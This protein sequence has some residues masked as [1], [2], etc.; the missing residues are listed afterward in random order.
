MDTKGILTNLLCNTKFS[1]MVAEVA[2]KPLMQTITDGI[3]KYLIDIPTNAIADGLTKIGLDSVGNVIGTVGDKAV[4]GLSNIAAGNIVG[5]KDLY[6]GADTLVG[7]ILPGGQKFAEGYLGQLY[8]GADKMFGGYLP[9]VGGAGY[10]APNATNATLATTGGDTMVSDGFLRSQDVYGPQF[11]DARLLDGTPMK[12]SP[13][14]TPLFSMAPPMSGIDKFMSIAQPTVKLAGAVGTIASMLDGKGGGGG[15]R[16]PTAAKGGNTGTRSSSGLSRRSNLDAPEDK[17]GGS[18][19]GL[20]MGR[21][22]ISDQIEASASSDTDAVTSGETN[23]ELG[24]TQATR[25]LESSAGMSPDQ[26]ANMA[27]GD[28]DNLIAEALATESAVE[29]QEEVEGEDVARDV[30]QNLVTPQPTAIQ[31]VHQPGSVGAFFA[32]PISQ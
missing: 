14:G 4:S 24:A 13:T 9:N 22:S 23:G 31:P 27:N 16:V 18:T 32:E 25:M 5:L 3:T 12:F 7:G 15:G 10:V 29:V 1:V 21:R 11:T 20:G 8:T 30:I 2:T 26:I 17:G 28:M 19:S 6:S